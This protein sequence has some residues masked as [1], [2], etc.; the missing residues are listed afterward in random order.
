VPRRGLRGVAVLTSDVRNLPAAERLLYW[1]T[2]RE[3]IRLRRE[4]GAPAPWTDDE[5][6]RTYRFC[7][8]RR[9]DD[10]VTRWLMEMWYGPHRGHP[11][12]LAG[13]ALAR[14]FNQPR[15]LAYVQDYV[16]NRPRLEWTKMAGE[17]KHLRNLG[18]PVFNAAYMVRCDGGVDKIDYVLEVVREISGV[19][20]R[21][22]SMEDDWSRLL[23]VRGVGSFMAGQ[24]VA[25][26]RHA[27]DGAWED[28]REWAPIGPGSK[29]GMNL[30]C[31][32]EPEHPLNQPQFLDELQLLIAYCREN[33]PG[34]LTSRL[35]AMDYQNVCCELFKYEKALSGRGRPKQLYSPS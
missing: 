35:E 9:M 21:A 4:A 13:A 14:F 12:T 23:S 2:E 6:L 8:V 7:N 22:A 16:W 17:L 26:L 24:I 31:G 20:T 30:F 25:D 15:T 29:K 10:R 33:L 1:I 32:R 28:A 11:N 34:D 19:N 18:P 3:A 27:V 5:I